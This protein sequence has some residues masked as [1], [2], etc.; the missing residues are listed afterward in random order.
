VVQAIA[1]AGADV[2]I[3]S[4]TNASPRRLEWNLHKDKR[5]SASLTESSVVG[6]V[7]I[8]GVSAF[9]II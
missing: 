5:S 9:L 7:S 6:S 1:K 4:R 8:S 2:I 3:S